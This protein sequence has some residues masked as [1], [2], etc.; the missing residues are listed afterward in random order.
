MTQKK[1]RGLLVTAS[2]AV[3]GLGLCGAANAVPTT[4]ED[5]IDFRPDRL[6][7]TFDSVVFT[8]NINDDGFVLGSDT[9][10][11][12]SLSFNLYDDRDRSSEV[13]LFSQ[14]GDLVSGL[15]FDLS[16]QENGG[17]TM[18][19]RWQLQNSGLL[20]VAITSLAGD[21]YLGSSTLRVNGDHKVPEPATLA[22][23]G[24]SLLGFG[25]IRRRRADA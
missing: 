6:V 17:W 25:L 15:W 19:G 22:L 8:H 14:P 12:Y 2:M 3:L 23:L 13:A 11:N 9:V 5:D 20:T 7:T 18:A 10:Y 21:F 16:G 24:A 4:W 1:K